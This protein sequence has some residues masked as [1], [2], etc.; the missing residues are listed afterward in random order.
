[1]HW[2]LKAAQKRLSGEVLSGQGSDGIEV[3][4]TSQKADSGWS[5]FLLV[6]KKTKG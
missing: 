4:S 1:V 3:F 2:F 6:V 5:N